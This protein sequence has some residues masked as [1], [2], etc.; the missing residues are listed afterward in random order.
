MFITLTQKI[1]R[2]EIKTAYS[3]VTVITMSNSKTF[4][5]VEGMVFKPIVT[6]W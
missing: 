1:L 6:N 3:T 2:W 5:I 4:E